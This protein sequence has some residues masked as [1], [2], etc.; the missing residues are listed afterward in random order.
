M[1]EPFPRGVGDFLRRAE[2]EMARGT[3]RQGAG[4]QERHAGGADSAPGDG[5]ARR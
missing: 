1:R 2:E 3:G 5:R 4:A